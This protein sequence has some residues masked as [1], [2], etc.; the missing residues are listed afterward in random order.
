MGVHATYT[1]GD[2]TASSDMCSGMLFLATVLLSFAVL[3]SFLPKY[4]PCCD[5]TWA[6][7]ESMEGP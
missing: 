4:F 2:V 5:A 3:E 6:V 1:N 7:C